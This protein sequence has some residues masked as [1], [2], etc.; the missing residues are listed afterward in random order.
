MHSNT[1]VPAAG[2]LDD[3]AVACWKMCALAGNVCL[4]LK[5]VLGVAMKLIDG[6]SLAMCV[7]GGLTTLL[8]G[9]AAVWA[10]TANG[11]HAMPRYPLAAAVLLVNVY[12]ISRLLLIVSSPSSWQHRLIADA[13]PAWAV[14]A[15]QALS[16]S[17]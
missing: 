2:G 12:C 14:R 9:S 5:C 16:G 3:D 11:C 15:S 17:R 1:A 13:A 6:R 8:L 7:C 4:H 10:G